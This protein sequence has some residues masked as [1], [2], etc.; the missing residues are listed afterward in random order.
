ML[1][2]LRDSISPPLQNVRIVY[3]H[4][5]KCGGTSI[6]QAMAELRPGEGYTIQILRAGRRTD[7]VAI[8]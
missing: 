6:R 3:L 2:R 4:I 8:R 7:L 1:D 5:P